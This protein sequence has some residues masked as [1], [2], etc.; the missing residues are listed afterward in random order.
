MWVIVHFRLKP[1]PF[2]KQFK[3]FQERVGKSIIQEKNRVPSLA[4]VPRYPSFLSTPN[5][6]LLLVTF[7]IWNWFLSGQMLLDPSF[8][9]LG[10]TRIWTQNSK[11][12]MRKKQLQKPFFPPGP[13]RN[14]PAWADISMINFAS[15]WTF[16]G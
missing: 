16:Q 14:P 7:N 11:Y 12:R 5:F 4:G 13:S 3:V 10:W 2:S 9:P 8:R 1:I 15:S 6:Q